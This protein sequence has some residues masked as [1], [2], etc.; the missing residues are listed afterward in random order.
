MQTQEQQTRTL[1]MFII[2]QNINKDAGYLISV[3]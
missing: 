1:N 3:G 2:I